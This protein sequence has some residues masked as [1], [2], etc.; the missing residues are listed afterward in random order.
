MAS[1]TSEKATTAKMASVAELASKRAINNSATNTTIVFNLVG[2]ASNAKAVGEDPLPTKV[3]YFIGNDPKKWQTNVKTYAR[4]RYQNVYPG[5]DLLYYGNNRQVEYDFLVSPGA[6]AGKI[7][8][9]VQGADALSVDAEGNLVLSKGGSQLYFQAPGIYQ[10][11]NGSHVKVSGKYFVQDSTHVGFTIAAH[12]R[13]KT[14]VIDPVLVYST[15]LGGRGDDYGNAV[16]VDASGNAYVTGTTDS[17]DFPLATLGSFN[18]NQQ[19]LFVAKL[20]VSGSTLLFADYFGG[21]SG[22]DQANSI[23]V[24]STGNTYVA[25]ATSSAD[26]PVFGA[27]QP[28]MAG[29]TNAFLTKFSSDGSSLVFSTYLGGSNYDYGEA[30]VVDSAG[31]AAIA[32]NTSSQNFPLANPYQSSISPDE[33]GDWGTYGFFSKFSADG[34]SLLYS[35]YLAGN[36]GADDWDASTL[37]TGLADDSSGNLY[38]VGSTDTTNFP[39]TSGAYMTA[40]PGTYQSVCFIAKFDTSGEMVYSSYLG[41]TGYSSPAGVAVD[42]SGYAYVAGYDDGQ[43][44]FPVTTTSICD[45]SSQNCNGT[46]VAKFDT[47]GAAL[48]YSTFLGPDNNSSPFGI[49]VDASGDA[50]V[51]AN[52]ES[53]PFTLV[54]PIEAYM[55][56]SDLL[57]VELDSSGSSQQFATFVGAAEDDSASGMA[58]DQTGAIY[59]TG[60]TDSQYFPAT[61]SAFQ[62]TW[63][64]QYDAFILKISP[65]NNSSPVIEPAVLQFSTVVVGVSGTPQSTI[66]RNMGTASLDI[67]SKSVTGDFAETD[68]CGTSVAA[69]SF[70]TV[71]VTFTPTAAGPRYGTIT[72]GD[73]AAGSP[74]F[75]SLVGEGSS[76]GVNLSSAS[77]SFPSTSVG[78]TSS[79]QTVTLLNAGNATLNISSIAA[80]ANFAETNTCPS[81]LA[82]GYSCQIA[83]TFTP[84]TGGPVSGSVTVIDDAP[85][86]PQVIS[87][88]GSA[89]DFDMSSS[90]GSASVSP[91]ASAAYPISISPVGGNFT[92]AVYLACANL[93][94][95]STCTVDPASVVPG[96][97][98][99]SVTVTI[100]T[101]GAAAQLSTGRHWELAW[102]K[103]APGVGMFGMILFGAGRRIRRFKSVLLLHLLIAAMFLWAG[104]GSGGSG[105]SSQAG[106]YTPAGTYTVSVIGQSGSVQ[107]ITQLTLTVQ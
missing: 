97:N 72:L 104:C 64:G 80:S 20:D 27:Y 95:Y 18:P 83:I 28:A 12:D 38:I 103:L 46:F 60:N 33:N 24:D 21:T 82:I 3:N 94:A 6:D 77:L 5:I 68:D 35:S 43:D 44:N 50:Y 56:G 7:Q 66:L 42:A 16:A 101:T 22:N 87:L 62:G 52:S 23:A 55:G 49:Q 73:N 69:G 99:A 31:E 9:S 79:A 34:S 36:L 105:Q 47:A 93:P 89:V 8:F 39:T 88:S 70:C 96:A 65:A 75:I 54:N 67:A 48:V 84:T 2:A 98:P 19:R 58:M 90:G 11:V 53:S 29:Y 86:S 4:V 74:H 51:V 63:G 37:I 107:H 106:R 14:L 13:S 1:G 41:G 100:K 81:A 10:Q 57:I 92:R 85:D 76:S 71:T 40:F 59:V 61:Q 45:P 91:G 25:G 26:F 32:G 17:P 102:W 15:F 30:V 78:E